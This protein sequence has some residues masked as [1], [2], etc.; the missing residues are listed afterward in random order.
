L[1]TSSP[2]TSCLISAIVVRI[3]IVCISAVSASIRI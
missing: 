3:G 1:S 2:T